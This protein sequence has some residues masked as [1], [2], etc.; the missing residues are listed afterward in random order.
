MI[1]IN[2]NKK[3]QL[4]PL[5]GLC[6]CEW[7]CITYG[8]WKCGA[9]HVPYWSHGPV[10][11][12]RG[13]MKLMM[14][15]QPCFYPSSRVC[16]CHLPLAFSRVSC[17]ACGSSKLPSWGFPC[18]SCHNDRS[19]FAGDLVKAKLGRV[20]YVAHG[21]QGCTS[22]YPSQGRNGMCLCGGNPRSV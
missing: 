15:N 8:V 16:F 10:S 17:F 3:K 20:L 9:F 6:L 2:N 1:K 22:A 11:G 18:L 19:I 5:V 4:F 14:K 12:R 21:V 7:L 13:Q